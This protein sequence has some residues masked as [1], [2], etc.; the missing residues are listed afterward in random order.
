[1]SFRTFE[2][3]VGKNSISPAV[4][5]NAG[6]QGEHNATELSFKLD[7]D[8]ISALNKEQTNGKKLYYRFDAYDGAGG[9]NS[10]EPKEVVSLST[11]YI[12]VLENWITK[13]GINLKVNLVF[14]AIKDNETEVEVFSGAVQLQLKNSPEGEDISGE[15]NESLSS[16]CVATQEYAKRAENAEQSA[17]ASEEVCTE[18]AEKTTEARLAL[19]E[20]AI[21]VFDGGTA[22]VTVREKITI[23]NAMSDVSKNSVENNVAK[24]YI[25]DKFDNLYNEPVSIENG[26]TGATTAEEARNNLGI[27]KMEYGITNCQVG[28]PSEPGS[29]IINFSEAFTNI[30]TISLTVNAGMNTNGKELHLG[31]IGVEKTQFSVSASGNSAGNINVHWIAIG[32]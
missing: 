20:G 29:T 11:S 16:L 23:D 12:Y 1:M 22:S 26:G 14:T 18:A 25:D 15:N 13:S 27:P 31:V 24:K 5:S 21:W 17:A 4:I 2:I 28:V 7:S 19:E 9:K 8:V 10:T 6:Y 30:P 3:N 32:T